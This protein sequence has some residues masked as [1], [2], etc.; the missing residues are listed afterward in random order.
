MARPAKELT[1]AEKAAKDKEK[2]DKFAKLGST[3]LNKALT[4]MAKMIPLA[5]KSLYSYTPEQIEKINDE[6]TKM[7]SKIATAFAGQK[8]SAGGVQL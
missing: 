8:V 1:D 6:F 5:N 4:E 2:A 3:R 7:T